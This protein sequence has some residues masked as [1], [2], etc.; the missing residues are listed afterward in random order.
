MEGLKDLNIRKRAV[1][2]RFTYLLLRVSVLKMIEI[3]ELIDAL[4]TSILVFPESNRILSSFWV[5]NHIALR[6][7]RRPGYPTRGLGHFSLR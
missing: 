4:L 1:E 3:I 6:S 2:V 5:S 7:E